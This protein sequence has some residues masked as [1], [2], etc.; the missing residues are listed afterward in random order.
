LRG[1]LVGFCFLGRGVADALRPDCC[2]AKVLL[3]LFV[4][5]WF[6]DNII[7]YQT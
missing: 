5:L 1:G 6:F 2:V 7:F 3:F 4:I